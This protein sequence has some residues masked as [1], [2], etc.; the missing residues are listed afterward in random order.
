MPTVPQE[1][2][3]DG[4]W[5]DLVTGIIYGPTARP[6]IIRDQALMDRIVASGLAVYTE[7]F[8]PASP[9]PI[10][11]TAPASG[12]FTTLSASG[13]LT[14]GSTISGNVDASG[15]I[16]GTTLNATA[17]SGAAIYAQGGFLDI[18]DGT[19]RVT[20]G[21]ASGAHVGTANNR[22]FSL[23]TNGANRLTFTGAGLSAYFS[24]GVSVGIGTI[25]PL[26]RWH[27][28]SATSAASPTLNSPAGASV[29]I[30]GNATYGLAIGN[31]VSNGDSW[32]QSM[33]WAGG[34]VAY[35][36]L[37]NPAGGNVGINTASPERA[38]HVVGS[39]RITALPTSPA[40]LSAGDL[41]NDSGTVKIA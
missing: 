40:G 27:I 4:P 36:L 2:R 1:V 25:S 21:I 16:R 3:F 12:A 30:G 15:F 6:Y 31:N 13:I 9:G 5:T 28:V 19:D 20:A 8:D 23:R 38:L 41:W 39:V 35:R 32:I 14:L 24:P 17:T 22:D 33:A 29:L 10:G 7:A 37:L 26:A 11:G 18:D 34:A